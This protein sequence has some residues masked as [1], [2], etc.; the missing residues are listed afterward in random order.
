MSRHEGK[1]AEL[2][3][4]EHDRVRNATSYVC[5][6]TLAGTDFESTVQMLLCGGVNSLPAVADMD[7]LSFM[8][9]E[10][11]ACMDEGVT[12][13]PIIDTTSYPKIYAYLDRRI[14]VQDGTKFGYDV[15]QAYGKMVDWLK[16][17][18]VSEHE[19]RERE[20]YNGMYY[21]TVNVRTVSTGLKIVVPSKNEQVDSVDE[22]TESTTGIE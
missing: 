6:V 19:F 13:I 22:Q 4:K 2:I 17:A 5:N 7:I 15:H 1:A 12:F 14:K 8:R 9:E 3:R 11:V 10:M 21:I 16:E 18:K 20:N